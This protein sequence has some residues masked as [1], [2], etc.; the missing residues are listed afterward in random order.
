MVVSVGGLIAILIVIRL[1]FRFAAH[2]TVDGFA[3]AFQSTVTVSPLSHHR[4][5]DGLQILCQLGACLETS[6]NPFDA[7]LDVLKVLGGSAT[8]GGVELAQRAEFYT[9]SFA[10][11]T[12]GDIDESVNDGL[13][14]GAGYCRGGR[15]LHGQHVD[16][17]RF[18]FDDVSS[19]L[20][21]AGANVG[22]DVRCVLHRV[23]SGITFHIRKGVV[24]CPPSPLP[25]QIGGGRIGRVSGFVNDLGEK[26]RTFRRQR[27]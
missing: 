4:I 7:G 18:L 16:G 24:A 21:F 26:A 9:V 15:D 19:H 17:V 2:N 23:L 1:W 8:N 11:V 13:H 27:S 6:A 3:T 10:K 25:R 20:L 5:R 12:H 22:G 14:V